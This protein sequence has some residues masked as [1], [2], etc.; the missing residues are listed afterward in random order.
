MWYAS[1]NGEHGAKLT[2]DIEITQLVMQRIYQQ[3]QQSGQKEL[4]D[5]LRQRMTELQPLIDQLNKRIDDA[6]RVSHV[7]F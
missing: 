4:A 2:D 1:L 7:Q 3:A 5:S 6:M